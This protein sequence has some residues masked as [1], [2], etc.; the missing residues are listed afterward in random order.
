MSEREK[1]VSVI[2]P[3]Y[4]TE[5][6]LAQCLSSILEQTLQDFEILCVDDGSTDGSLALLRQ[7]AQRDPRIRVLTQ[8]NAYAGVA[9]NHALRHAQGKY[10]AFLDSDDFFAPDL[11]EK[12]Y[13]QCEQENADICAY[14]AITYNQQTGKVE[15]RSRGIYKEELPENRPFCADDIPAHIFSALTDVVSNKL[16]RRSFI[17]AEGIRFL[18]LLCTNDQYFS[19]V[20]LACA[21]RITVVEEIFYYHRLNHSGNTRTKRHLMP[22]SFYESWQAVAQTLKE[23]G[24]YEA[25]EQ[26]LL[27]VLL[28][29]AVS[30][31]RFFIDAEAEEAYRIT[32][33]ALQQ[34]ILPFLG[35]EDR[36]PA[37]FASPRNYEEALAVQSH[38]LTAYLLRTMGKRTDQL[39]HAKDTIQRLRGRIEGMQ[40]RIEAQNRRIDARDRRIGR[41][42]QRIGRLQKSLRA[43]KK[44]T[45]HIKASRTYRLAQW[46][47]AP[48][49]FLRRA[50]AG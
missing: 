50:K 43:Q 36:G 35:L 40:K 33:E 20:A 37:Y 1:K 38:T 14:L 47:G 42:K 48:L 11:L 24:R 27:N 28:R 13:R 26:G 4:N 23:K 2:L 44:Q 46:F 39:A 25:L 22:L 34:E 49:R 31:V 32:Y 10:V 21:Q 18:P 29:A 9:R 12:T 7:Y 16:F 6:Y 19:Y 30:R 3:V 45:A 17:E 5:P 41:L 8:Q 15:G